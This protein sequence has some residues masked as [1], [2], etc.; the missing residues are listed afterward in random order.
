MV[1]MSTVVEIFELEILIHVFHKKG[2]FV[3]RQGKLQ[4]THT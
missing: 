2:Q 1:Y 3:F 4:M